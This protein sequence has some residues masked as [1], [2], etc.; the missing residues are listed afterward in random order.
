M[1][2]WMERFLNPENRDKPKIRYWIPHGVMSEEGIVK[3]VA[4]IAERGFG[5]IEAVS[6]TRG[7][8][9]AFYTRENTWGSKMW[10]EKINILLREA[11]KYGLRVDISNG[12]G[13][14]IVDITVTHADA[15]TTLYELAYGLKI[16]EA[17]ERY[18]GLP[19]L[20]EILHEEGTLKCLAVSMYRINPV[21]EKTLDFETYTALP[22]SG[23]I[24]VTAGADGQYALF[25]FYGRPAVQKY[26]EFYVMDHFS[27]KATD[28]VMDYWEQN[29]LPALSE[30]IDALENIFCDSLEYRVD[31]EWTRTFAEDFKA[32]KGYSILP[33][34]PCLGCETKSMPTTITYFAREGVVYQPSRNE[35]MYPRS[36]FCCYTFSDS[37]LSHKVN[38]DYFEMTTYL[39]AEKHVKHM[40]ERAEKMGIGVRYQVAYGKPLEVEC[41]ALYP[42]IPENEGMI[43]LFDRFRLMAGTVHLARKPLYSFE[44]A[45]EAFNSYGQTHEDILW[46]MK[47]AYAGGM[48][49]Q[50]LHGG[51]YCGYYDGDGNQNGLGPGINWPGFEGFTRRTWTNAW[52]RTLDKKG[53]SEVWK[54]MGRVN[55]LLRN[56]HKVDLA[57]YKQTYLNN[58]A[59][60]GDGSTQV[61]D[62][63]WLNQCGFT[64]EFLSA[65]LLKHE[66]CK[67][68][69]GV[70]DADGASYKAFIVDNETFMDYDSA[71]EIKEFAEK[72]L[73]VFFVGELPSRLAMQSDVHTDAE[74]SALVRSIPHI[75][76]TNLWVIPQ[77]LKEIGILPDMMPDTPAT[78]YPVHVKVNASDFY[79][80]YNGNILMPPDERTKYPDLDKERMML[81]FDGFLSLSG[82]GDV[83]ELDAFS[84][85]VKKIPAVQ[86]D[87]HVEFETHFVRDEAKVFAVLPK[88]D[89]EKLGI[90]GEEEKA[91]KQ[92]AEMEL[93]DF[94]LHITEILPP[95]NR[96]GTF[97]ESVYQKKEPTALNELKPWCEIGGLERTC[98]IGVYETVFDLESVPE[99]AVLCLEKVTDTYKVC[100]NGVEM[101]FAD[102]VKKETDISSALKAGE[103]QIEITVYT[104]LQNVASLDF[105][106]AEGKKTE[107]QKVGLWGKVKVKIYD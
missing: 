93:S 63:N 22:T 6:M 76:V 5:S 49:A 14:P 46:W 92:V 105:L 68:K 70:L 88:E 60:K 30:N 103:N 32:R 8:P 79:Y 44:C 15:E 29:I 38:T 13:W 59:G 40:Q 104:T 23:E 56:P 10:L 82:K 7:L 96:I 61:C 36:N 28:S 72:G 94:T 87:G 33:Y 45:A 97:Y 65:K 26:G 102:P 25:A 37:I 54:Y 51:H 11:K 85:A 71:L 2:K 86:R 98:G 43:P 64:Y 69:N 75:F 16:L 106:L 47:R 90:S 24:E 62:S 99:Q 12:P 20:P 67:V 83:Y 35:S 58:W 101:P 27:E 57:F 41:A 39:Y 52:N 77:K 3:D 78:L 4:D 74:L 55:F 66:N 100:V 91:L 107:P 1:Q 18:K 17:G 53:Q 19:P 80:V 73:P 95:E 50:V 81:P 21:G 48:N 89:A 31:L 9:D 84:G 34:L 42:A